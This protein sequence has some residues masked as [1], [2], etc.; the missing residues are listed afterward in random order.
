MYLTIT[1]A[2]VAMRDHVATLPPDAD[3]DDLGIAADTLLSLTNAL[4]DA[5]DLARDL[6]LVPGDLPPFIAGPD[7][8]T[9]FAVAHPEGPLP[10]VLVSWIH[11][12]VPTPDWVPT[13]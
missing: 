7:A 11:A 6:A 12:N 2:W 10:P 8:S 9:W 4:G 3:P 13:T 1:D 5:S